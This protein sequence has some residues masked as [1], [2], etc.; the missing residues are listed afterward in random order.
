MTTAASPD[1]V[2][3]DN[4]MPGRSGIEALPDLYAAGAAFVIMHTAHANQADRETA[5]RLGAAVIDKTG[6]I[7]LLIDAIRRAA[8]GEI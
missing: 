3:L 1:V 5:V 4:Q 8:R 6:D 7:G 2:I